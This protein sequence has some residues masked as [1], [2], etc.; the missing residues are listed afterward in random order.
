MDVV[1]TASRLKRD[2]TTVTEQETTQYRHLGYPSG[3]V[4]LPEQ[5]GSGSQREHHQ[6]LQAIDAHRVFQAIVD[7]LSV[8]SRHALA[9]GRIHS[10]DQFMDL[11]PDMMVGWP[12]TGSKTVAEIMNARRRLGEQEDLTKREGRSLCA[13]QVSGVLGLPAEAIGRYSGRPLLQKRA[14][15]PAKAVRAADE[16]ASWSVLK[17]TVPDLLSSEHQFAD[18]LLVAV[19]QE[20]IVDVVDLPPDD[21]LRLCAAAIYKDDQFDVLFFLTLGYLAELRISAQSLDT[22]ASALAAKAGCCRGD[23]RSGFTN[24]LSDVSIVSEA[25]IAPLRNLR[26][27]SFDVP[28]EVLLT[29]A[30]RDL[31]TWGDLVGLSERSVAEAYESPLCAVPLIRAMWRTKLFAQ[32]AIDRVSGLPSACFAGFEPMMQAYIGLAAG[33]P[34]DRDLLE[35]RLGLYQNRKWTL[36][37]LASLLGLTRERVRQVE[38]KLVKALRLSNKRMLLARFWMAADEVLRVSGG[39]CT[40]AELAEQIAAKLEW[41]SHPPITPLVSLLQ[42]CEHL[43]VDKQAELICDPSHSCCECEAI[44]SVLE[45][46][47]AEDKSER[48]THQVVEELLAQCAQSEACPHL[49]QHLTM[50][51]GFVRFVARKI[52]GIRVKD[53]VVY[54]RDT[55][56]GRRGSRVQ[57]VE[58][59]LN[60]GGMGQEPESEEDYASSSYRIVLEP[61]SAKLITDVMTAHF[62]NGFRTSSPIELLRF[63]RFAAEDSGDE[64]S[65]TDE[66]LVRA[67]ASCGTFSDGKVYVISGEIERR[68]QEEVD[69]AISSGAGMIFY[70]SFYARHGE[71][72]FAGSV[73]S[74]EMLRGILAKLYPRYTY[75]ANCFSAKAENGAELSKIKSEIMR[76]WGSDVILNYKQLCERLP[77][78]PLDKMKTVLALN[79]DFVWNAT[80]VYTHVGKVDV[81]DEE[82]VAIADYVAAACRS[83]G[84][85]SLSDVPLGEIASRNHELTLTAI[86]SAVFEIVLADK[87]DRHG[88]IITRVGDALDALTI[89]KEHCRTLDRCSLQDLLEF[90]RDL[91]GE[92][93]RWIPMEAGYATMVRADED[94]YIAEKYVHFDAAEIDDALDL[95]VTGQ[96]L[97]L[98][99]VTTF[100]AFPHCGQAWNLFVL[101][102]YC[103][104]FS[105]RFRFQVLSANSR[106]A[107]AIVRSGC[108]LSYF[109]IMADAVAESEVPLEKTAV[110]DFL[111]RSG[112]IGRRSYAKIDELVEQAKV[113]RESR[114]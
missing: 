42:F 66:E 9:Y 98:R 41:E 90:E 25:E 64:I 6:D 71:W 63:R 81:T 51:E 91:T 101:E 7:S 48:A 57:L 35:R 37:E 105:E 87:Y 109:E 10:L 45:C 56:S 86:H 11:H 15:V 80:E 89:M 5:D 72:L 17:K 33:T 73:I 61:A 27:D 79:S 30:S 18:G 97:P 84:Y 28:Q 26:I 95:F 2:V 77:Y 110:I 20:P 99:S 29:L 8:R 58:S 19:G 96:Y 70:N 22:L 21:W 24:R 55:R 13:D 85:S 3:Q 23:L 100:A 94:K 4:G 50:S 78:I 69:L 39:V 106:N 114:T 74:E 49:S 83:V 113:L 108:H 107:G 16:L 14:T 62:P 47:F 67:I 76:V 112:Y 82:C 34:R 104:R 38:Q 65:A 44:V 88:K 1:D 36:D 92:S 52:D 53:G 59:V 102:S 68:I 43:H 12:N 111:C 32:E 75:K 40:F 103:R 54:C 46:Q 31:V 93:H 60:S